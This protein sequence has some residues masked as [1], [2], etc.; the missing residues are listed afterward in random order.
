MKKRKKTTK[1][2]KIKGKIPFFY[3]SF[4]VFY[5][6]FFLSFYSSLSF[7]LPIFQTQ[8]K[9]NRIVNKKVNK[10]ES[11]RKNIIIK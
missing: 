4:V 9:K 6:L 2:R 10:D 1:E 3:F 8:N 11:K 5:F 7:Y